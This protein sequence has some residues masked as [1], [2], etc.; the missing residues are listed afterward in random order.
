MRKVLLLTLLLFCVLLQQAAAQTRAITGR[1]TD[2]GSNEGLPGVTVLVKGTQVG[3]ATD[4]SGNYSI[5][6]PENA[7]TL[8]FSF[9]GYTSVE[10]AI[11]NVTTLNVAMAP[12]AKQLGEVV[13]RPW[14]W[15]EPATPCPMPPPRWKPKPSRPPAT[16]TSST[17]CRER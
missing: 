14:A 16:P 10:R 2:A 13:V 1:V 12:D 4:G 9:I 6:V 5:N 17:P 7:T 3:T 8:V 11:G 15:K